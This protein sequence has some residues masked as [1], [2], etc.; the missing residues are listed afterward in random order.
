MKADSRPTAGSILQYA[1]LGWRD[2]ELR[3]LVLAIWLACAATTMISFFADRLER[4]LQT[5]AGRM[6]GG[7]LVIRSSREAPAAWWQQ[8]QA[9]GLAA[10]VEVFEFPSMAGAGEHFA[11]ASIKAVGEGYP[12]YGQAQIQRQTQAEPERLQRGPQPGEVWLEPRLLDLLQLQLGDELQL[13]YAKLKVAALLLEEPDPVFDF[14]SLSPRLMMHAAD[15]PSTQLIQPGSRIRYRYL[16][17]GNGAEIE[18]FKAWLEPQLGPGARIQDPQQGN[19]RLAAA[20]ERVRQYLSLGSVLAVVL[21]G[22]TLALAARHYSQRHVD[23]IA[24]WR[25]LGL[26][27]STLAWMLG[28]RLGWLSLLAVLL[29]VAS[30]A[31]AQQGLVLIFADWLPNPMPT[32]SWVPAWSGVLTA[33]LLL[34]ALV[35]PDWWQLLKV[36]PL[37]V[38]RREISWPQLGRWLSLG[39]A[40][41]ALLGWLWLQSREPRLTLAMGAGLVVALGL[42]YGLAWLLV[43]A[44]KDRLGQCL[45]LGS[46]APLQIAAFSLVGIAIGLAMLMRTELIA[47]WQQQL[48]EQAPNYFALNI[49]PWER[50]AVADFMQQ[51]GWDD[52][53]L[54]PLARGRVVAI[55]DQ[56]V[57][58]QPGVS[59]EGRHTLERELNLTWAEQPGNDNAILE[60]QFWPA[61]SQGAEFSAEQ[62]FAESLNLKLGDELRFDIGGSLVSAKLTSIRT[63]DWN[64]FNPNFFVIFSPKVLG[65]L[66]SAAMTSFYVAPEQEQRLTEFSQRWPTVSLVGINPLLEQFRRILSQLTQAVQYLF[67]FLLLAAWLVLVAVIQINLPERQREQLVLHTLGVPRAL[68]RRR[69]RWEFLCL[70]GLA[71]VLAAVATLLLGWL[72]FV[73]LLGWGMPQPWWLVFWPVLAALMVTLPALWMLRGIGQQ[74]PWQWLRQLD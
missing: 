49:Q 11:L 70:G 37:R 10:P 5:Q 61:D 44:L 67:V 21:A 6:L 56:P 48:P 24:L 63:V 27:R 4:G 3:L 66:A 43:K 53:P 47:S 9:L 39:L 34:G 64:S 71:G 14:S 72:V 19:P 26:K 46:W 52:N 16:F 30:G 65:E 42:I 57:E 40:L 41:L 33:L 60:G 13:G 73:L 74:P 28:A 35:L 51:Q 25:C 58:Q 22:I 18:R 68:L 36:S 2:R 7:D 8:A 62:G 1:R 38:F 55:N 20:L 15:L 45:P 69:L 29:G 50:Q 32:L 31:L 59:K 12:L 17:A 54:Y 23:E